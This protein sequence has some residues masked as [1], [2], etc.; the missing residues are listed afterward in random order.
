MLNAHHDAGE[1][2]GGQSVEQEKEA[3]VRERPEAGD[4]AGR[5]QQHLQ[6]K[7]NCRVDLGLEAGGMVGNR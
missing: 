5:R 3:A 7:Y 6:G 4:H 1:V 2:D